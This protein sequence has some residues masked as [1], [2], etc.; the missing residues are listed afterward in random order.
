MR[1]ASAPNKS[2]LLLASPCIP[3]LVTQVIKRTLLGVNLCER[4][5][6][7]LGAGQDALYDASIGNLVGISELISL[8]QSSHLLSRK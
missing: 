7:Q 5:L 1:N 2:L 8:I 4:G 6:V 3:F